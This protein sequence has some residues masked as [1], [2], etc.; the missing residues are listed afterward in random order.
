MD[1][2]EKSS[3]FF[4]NRPLGLADRQ[5]HLI[6]SLFNR[7][8]TGINANP[9]FTYSPATGAKPLRRQFS[10]MARGTRKF[11]IYSR[12]PALVPPPD[13]LNPPKGCRSTRAPV[14]V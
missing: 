3:V 12:P 2:T 11:S 5:N 6:S 1:K 7:E 9:A 4:C 8:W 10:V 14:I 13:I